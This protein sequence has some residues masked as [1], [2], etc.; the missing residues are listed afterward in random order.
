MLSFESLFSCAT[1]ILMDF[2]RYVLETLSQ[3]AYGRNTISMQEN[4]QFL[5]AWRDSNLICSRNPGNEMTKLNDRT[6]FSITWQWRKIENIF[7]EQYFF[8][9]FFAYF[10][11]LYQQCTVLYHCSKIFSSEM[12]R[13]KF[14]FEFSSLMRWL[15]TVFSRKI[16]NSPIKH[17]DKRKIRNF[18]ILFR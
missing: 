2:F 15:R 10:Q 9:D 14:K 7:F 1:I 18:W 12:K 6:F 4:E 5:L 3:I 17:W 8:H 13:F 11:I 16:K